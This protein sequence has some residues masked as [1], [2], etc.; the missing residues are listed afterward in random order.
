MVIKTSREAIFVL[1]NHWGITGLNNG[2]NTFLLSYYK[3][4]NQNSVCSR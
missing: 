2:R 3:L 4:G 1:C